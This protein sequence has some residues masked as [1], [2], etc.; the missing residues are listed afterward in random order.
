MPEPDL[1]LEFGRPLAD[2]DR[3]TDA[4]LTGLAHRINVADHVVGPM[5]GSPPPVRWL[6][7]AWQAGPYVGDLWFLGGRLRMGRLSD[8][9]VGRPSVA[10]PYLAAVW[11]AG[12]EGATRHGPPAIRADAFHIGGSLRG[13]LDVRSTVRLRAK[14]SSNVASVYRRR[15]LGN[16]ISCALVAADQSIRRQM[17]DDRWRTK[18]AQEILP[19]L[20]EAVGRR[21][22]VPT[23]SELARIRYTPITRPFRDLAEL[24]V[25]IVRQDPVVT[26]TERGQPQGLL[27]EV[28]EA[29]ALAL[30]HGCATSSVR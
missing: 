26:T 2:V 14:G 18:R 6:D 30:E 29:D 8:L 11:C 1:Q 22:A 9:D 24:S 27:I 12:L 10:A 13:R 4:W 20:Y 16:A 17:G 28:G 15:E 23:S 21:A 19:S 7:G 25:R 3:E 5:S